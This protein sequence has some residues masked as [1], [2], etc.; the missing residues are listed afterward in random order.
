MR[1]IKRDRERDRGKDRDRM[2]GR[3]IEKGTDKYKR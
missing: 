2:R 1:K 3:E